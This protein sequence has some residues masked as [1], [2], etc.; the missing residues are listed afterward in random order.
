MPYAIEIDTTARLVAIKVYGTF[1]AE[2]LMR[3][4][5]EMREHDNFDGEFYELLDF[6]AANTGDIGPDDLRDFM[7]RPVA[8]SPE[9]RRAFVMANSF[10]ALGLG[11]MF[12]LLRDNAAGKIRVFTEMDEAR[13][14]LKLSG[15]D[16]AR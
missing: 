11:R 8:F 1:T 14:W 16:T 9:S 2:D 10:V 6:R 3:A 4:D 12:K 7:S 13:R 15:D 5:D